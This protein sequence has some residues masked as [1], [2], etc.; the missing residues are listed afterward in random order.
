MVSNLAGVAVANDTRND[1]IIRGNSPMGVLWRLDGFDIPNPN[2]FGAMGGT[3]GPI[4]MINNN[5]L[6]NSDFFTGAFPAEFGN[7]TSGVF[8]LRLRNGNANR[9]EFLGSVGFNGFELGAEGPISRNTGA[10]YMINARYSFL[11]FLSMFMPIFGVPKYQDLCAKV[12]IPLRSGNLSVVALLGANEIET[13][14]DMLDDLITWQPGDEGQDMKMSNSQV[15]TGVNY[16]ARFSASTRL[17]N[18]FSY[19]YFSSALDMDVF[20]YPET[21][22]TRPWLFT[23]HSEGRMAWTSTLHHRFDSRNFLMVGTGADYFMTR[24]DSRFYEIEGAPP[25]IEHDANKN[26]TLLKGFTQWQHRISDRFSITPGVYAHLFTFNGDFSVEPR[27]GMR[28]TLNERSSVSFGTGLHSQLPPRLIIFYK[29]ANGNRPNEKLGMSRSWQAVAG[30]DLRITDGMRLKT[31]IYYQHLYNIP[32]THE[33]PAESILN[34]GVDF[35]N[36][37]NFTYVNSGTG[38]NYGIELTLEKFFDDNYYFLITGS[39]YD[40]RYRGYD[41][42]ERHSAF[43][44]NFALNVV[45]GY[46]WKLSRN[47]LL[48]VNAKVAY[49]GAR[50]YTPVSI[51]RFGGTHVFDWERAYTQRLP[52]YFRADLGVNMKRNYERVAIEWFFEVTNLTN[53]QNVWQQVYNTSLEEYQRMYQF[54]FMPMGG[55]RVYF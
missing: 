26:S 13:R 12:N 43:A 24:L 40:A 50:R 25:H 32:V 9:H 37:W 27:L 41:G 34:L 33:Y 52:V 10:S 42:V 38:R 2:H 15:F 14:E 35:Y 7:A 6:T 36:N 21:T 39:L 31:E 48:S 46:E 11:E 8:D 54:G 1:I 23:T 28:W 17:E 4:G 45:A 44:G 53:R 49:M 55:V 16:T 22:T 20:V 19:Q 3:G 5:Q 18:R 47:R 51:D 30:Y 29:D